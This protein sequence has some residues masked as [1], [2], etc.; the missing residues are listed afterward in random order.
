MGGLKNKLSI[1]NTPIGDIIVVDKE[2]T[3]IEG[4]NPPQKGVWMYRV[5]ITNTQTGKRMIA[6]ATF[7][8]KKKAEEW[9]EAFKKATK[10]ADAKVVK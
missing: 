10:N 6:G 9:A 3:T 4:V 1:D 2:N 7:S 8:S 5:E